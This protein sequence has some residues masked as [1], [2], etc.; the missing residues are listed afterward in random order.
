[1]PTLRELR[2]LEPVQQAVP[3]SGSSDS[4]DLQRGSL[5][6]I[7]M[8]LLAAAIVAHARIQPQRQQLDTARPAFQELEFDIQRLTPLQAWEAW[9]YFQEQ[10]LQVR[11]TP[12]YLENQAK[13][14][15]LSYF[16]YGAWACAG[17]GAVLAGLSLVWPRQWA[18]LQGRLS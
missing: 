2:R 17:L 6:V 10:D 7:G 14:R 4:W 5:F 8:V 15:E 11:A 13:Y 1:V 18:S 16:L 9:E 3:T 12:Q